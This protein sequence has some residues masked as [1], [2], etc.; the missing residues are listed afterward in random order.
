MIHY[1]D[2]P[3]NSLSDLDCKTTWEIPFEEVP[4]IL[5]AKELQK[6]SEGQLKTHS[7]S[8]PTVSI[9]TNPVNA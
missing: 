7:D 3:H 8:T 5:N 2:D 1:T 6:M 9:T 4:M